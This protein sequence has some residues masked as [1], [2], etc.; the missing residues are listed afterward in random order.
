MASPLSSLSPKPRSCL[1][2][3][4][5]TTHPPAA[6]LP[7]IPALPN[8]LQALRAQLGG[9]YWRISIM[10]SWLKHVASPKIS[11]QELDAC[12]TRARRRDSDELRTQNSTWACQIP[13]PRW[14]E[15]SRGQQAAGS[16]DHACRGPRIRSLP[17][18]CLETMP[19]SP[20]PPPRAG[21]RLSRCVELRC[22]SAWVLELGEVQEGLG[23][24]DRWDG[25]ESHG[26]MPIFLKLCGLPPPR[27]SLAFFR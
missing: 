16:R 26:D 20:A 12:G 27:R 2:F 23:E 3:A 9:I 25:T 1:K 15:A 14:Q 17:R 5:T 13:Q 8:Q 4:A 7:A 6:P 18:S 10:G 19:P 24:P 11:P 21:P 22:R